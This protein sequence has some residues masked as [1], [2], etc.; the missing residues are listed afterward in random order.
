MSKEV[1]TE[2][3]HKNEVYKW[4]KQQQVAQKEYRASVPCCRDGIR[5]VRANLELLQGAGDVKKN[6]KGF[7]KYMNSKR[8]T[9]EIIVPLLNGLGKLMT[10]GHQKGQ[11]T[12]HLLCLSLHQ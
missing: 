7:H 12:Q 10:R 4:W 9:R 5:K 1:L 8:K 11:C 2:L 6:K 3:G